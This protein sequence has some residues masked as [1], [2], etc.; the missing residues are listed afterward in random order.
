M[1]QLSPLPPVSYIWPQRQQ[2]RRELETLEFLSWGRSPKS[3]NN[4]CIVILS[5]TRWKRLP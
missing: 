5:S 1:Q 3:Q 4:A 2:P